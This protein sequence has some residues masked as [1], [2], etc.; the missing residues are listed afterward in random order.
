MNHIEIKIMAKQ[1]TFGSLKEG[2]YFWTANPGGVN[3]VAVKYVHNV[4]VDNISLSFSYYAPS[5]TTNKA[6]R[7]IENE[8]ARIYWYVDKKDAQKKA[9]EL[10]RRAIKDMELQLAHMYKKLRACKEKWK[11]SIQVAL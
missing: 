5:Q 1:R 10:Q 4:D 8:P 6:A 3:R 7:A 11:D 9:I 2:S